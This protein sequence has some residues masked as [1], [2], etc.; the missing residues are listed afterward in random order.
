M[1]IRDRSGEISVQPRRQM[2]AI[3]DGRY[4]H[5]VYRKIRP[6]LGPHFLRD[7]AMKFADSIAQR[8][9]FERQDRHGEA[10][11][12]IVRVLA[13]ERKQLVEVDPRGCTVLAEV[14]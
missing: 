9:R 1:C 3:C 13:S 7:M 10:I 5:F 14:L 6:K 2:Y 4:R 12:R 11:G 8:G